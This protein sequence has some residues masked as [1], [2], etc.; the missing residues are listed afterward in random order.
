MAV[1]VLVGM[2]PGI[3]CR[4]DGLLMVLMEYA[5]YKA[6]LHGIG[7]MAIHVEVVWVHGP[8]ALTL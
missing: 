7:E 5:Q 1:A 2:M 6:T 8:F 3:S 4:P